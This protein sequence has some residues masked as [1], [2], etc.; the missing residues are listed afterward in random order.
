[1]RA[2][3]CVLLIKADE[4][5]FSWFLKELGRRTRGLEVPQNGLAEMSPNAR[6]NQLRGLV[7]LWKQDMDNYSTVEVCIACAIIQL[8]LCWGL[9]ARAI[10]HSY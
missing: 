7:R 10:A 3:R 4:K 6:A 9:F 8:G 2:H 5:G 1:M